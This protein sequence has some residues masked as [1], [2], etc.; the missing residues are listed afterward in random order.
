MLGVEGLSGLAR[1]SISQVSRGKLIPLSR[2]LH[3]NGHNLF[4]K[5]VR[6]WLMISVIIINDADT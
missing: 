5:Q 1:Q 4:I 2:W 6:Q 3:R